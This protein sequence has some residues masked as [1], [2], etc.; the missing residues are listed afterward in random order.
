MIVFRRSETILFEV[1]IK[2]DTVIIENQH[3]NNLYDPVI[4]HV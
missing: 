4:M 3:N 2:V 1:T